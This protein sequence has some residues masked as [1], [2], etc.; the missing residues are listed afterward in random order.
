MTLVEVVR[1][2]VPSAVQIGAKLSHTLLPLSSIQIFRNCLRLRRTLGRVF[3][4]PAF[5]AAASVCESAREMLLLGSGGC[6][7]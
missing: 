6:P 7:L 3:S 2:G 4:A 5:M 1:G